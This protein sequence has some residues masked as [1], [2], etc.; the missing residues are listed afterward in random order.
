MNTQNKEDLQPSREQIIYANLLIIGV[1]TG[2]FI[3][4]ATYAIYVTGILPEYH[5]QRL[6]GDLLFAAETYLRNRG[7][8]YLQV[9]TLSD[10]QPDA[11]FAKTR[12]FYLA[13]GFTPLEEI[14]TLWGEA[15]PALIFI[16][17]L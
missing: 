9:K 12:A 14:K 11:A 16:K 13:M 2:I 4:V 17:I 1:W 10:S 5:R 3:L 8:T 6:G 15:N 7:V